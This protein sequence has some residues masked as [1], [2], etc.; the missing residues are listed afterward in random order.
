VKY[1]AGTGVTG[2]I[3]VHRYI[4]T[5]HLDRKDEKYHILVMT[6]APQK[7]GRPLNFRDFP[8]DLYWLAKMCAANRHQ[9]LKAYVVD[10]LR[11][12][13]ERDSKQASGSVILR[14][15]RNPAG[16]KT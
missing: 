14:T 5:C 15:H 9:P 8:E 1:A 16:D 2:P 10:A 12:A 6:K 3:L 4:M 13:T 7:K 11:E